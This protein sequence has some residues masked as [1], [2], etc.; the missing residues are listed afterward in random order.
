MSMSGF[1][2]AFDAD[3]LSAMAEDHSLID[4]WIF[5][6]EKYLLETDV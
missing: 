5:E 4:Q 2:K 3:Q 1:F 6:E